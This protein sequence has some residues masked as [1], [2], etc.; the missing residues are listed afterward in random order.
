DGDAN[1]VRELLQVGR[2]VLV[3]IVLREGRRHVRRRADR[4][5]LLDARVGRII[6]LTIEINLL[7]RHLGGAF[8]AAHKID[9]VAAWSDGVDVHDDKVALAH[10][11][12]GSPA[13]VGAGVAARGDDNVVDDLAARREHEL[14]HFGLDL[15]LTDARLEPL[16][17]DLPHGGIADAAGLFK[18]LDLVNRLDDAGSGH[19]GPSIHHVQAALLE[20]AEDGEVDVAD[21][22]AF[23]TPT[24][25]VQ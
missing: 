24:C 12:V 20:R 16:I 19:R 21:A 25:V 22:D 5:Q 3:I 1:A 11:L 7:L 14:V 6:D 17:L 2:S 4:A 23:A 18:E 13:T 8:K 10:D 9:E 15:A